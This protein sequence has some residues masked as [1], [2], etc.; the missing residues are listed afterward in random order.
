LRMDCTRSSRSASMASSSSAAFTILQRTAEQDC[1]PVADQ[2]ARDLHCLRARDEYRYRDSKSDPRVARSARESPA[3]IL[4]RN[5]VPG[6]PPLTNAPKRAKPGATG[7]Q[8]AVSVGLPRGQPPGLIAARQGK[9]AQTRGPTRTRARMA[10]CSRSSAPGEVGMLPNGAAP[11]KPR[12]HGVSFRA[13]G[14]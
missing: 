8:L 9:Q 5:R 2:S 12:A 3:G 13:A 7:S 14:C 11:F 4:E 1:G 6:A 10:G